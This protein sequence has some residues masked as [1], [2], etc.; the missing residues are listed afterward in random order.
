MVK[1]KL[2][3]YAFIFN[4]WFNRKILNNKI[5]SV[6][7]NDKLRRIG[8]SK[9]LYKLA[10][11][12]DAIVINPYSKVNRQYKDNMI[13]MS[14]SHFIKLSESYGFRPYCVLIDEGCTDREIREIMDI[15]TDK[16]LMG[17]C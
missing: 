14:P 15:C 9:Y 10:K 1:F 13:I 8:K 5:I 4:C 17:Y 6:T 7:Y 3:Y 16:V 12:H 11:K 2:R